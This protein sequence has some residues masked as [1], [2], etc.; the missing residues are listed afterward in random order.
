MT[1]EFYRKSESDQ[2]IDQSSQTFLLNQ[3]Y[4][5]QPRMFLPKEQYCPR[6]WA[7][8]V[9]NIVFWCEHNEGGHFSSVEQAEKF[10]K[11]IQNFVTSREVKMVLKNYMVVIRLK[12]LLS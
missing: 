1:R 5:P 7:T 6:D 4:N 12:K 9:A 2:G 10:L 8:R 3:H 11:C